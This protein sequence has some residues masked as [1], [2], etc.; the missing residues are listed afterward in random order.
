MGKNLLLWLIIAAVL[1]TVFNN[2]NVKPEPETVSYTDFIEQ[3][4]TD[5]VERVEIDGLVIRGQ[6]RNGDEFQV[7]R[8]DVYDQKLM[9]DL[10]NHN[11]ETV[12]R[13][14][15]RARPGAAFA[16]SLAVLAE[17]KRLRRDSLA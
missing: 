13:L 3:V 8:P 6:R 4:R 12:P 5:Q 17:A 7:V 15:R 16:R 9:D 2:F 10:Y 14:Y 1:L 11:V